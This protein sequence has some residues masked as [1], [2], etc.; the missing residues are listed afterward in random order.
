MD[1]DNNPVFSFDVPYGWI[2]KSGD[3]FYYCLQHFPRP[4]AVRFEDGKWKEVP[5]DRFPSDVN[6]ID[7][8]EAMA[9]FGN[10]LPN[11]ALQEIQRRMGE[12]AVEEWTKQGEKNPRKVIGWAFRAEE[13]MDVT[14]SD[15]STDAALIADIREKGYLLTWEDIQELQLRP[16]FDT[17]ETV[18]FFD[19]RDFGFLIAS[20]QGNFDPCSYM[21]YVF[22]GSVPAEKLVAPK[23]GL[24][25]GLEEA[26]HCF[27]L[28]EAE[29][30]RLQ[31]ELQKPC[32]TP[33]I[34]F[35]P[36]KKPENGYYFP[37][38]R[39]TLQREG[40]AESIS[41]PIQLLRR[42]KEGDI[43]ALRNNPNCLI[44]ENAALHEDHVLLGLQVTDDINE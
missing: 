22:A 30:T 28:E 41:L 21:D 34:F 27:V 11:Q 1:D 18:S 35:F 40:G 43:A 20:S 26:P 13:H 16:I 44:I 29:W 39:V 32:K 2:G 14:E 38:Q 5:M 33:F 25:A 7:T 37:N 6:P 19:M 24:Y 15:A 23:E 36:V 8:E 9:L 4:A 42:G 17:Y 12:E 31:S 3:G 10:A